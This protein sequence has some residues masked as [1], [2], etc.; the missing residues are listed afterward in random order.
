[1]TLGQALAAEVWLIVP[2][3]DRWLSSRLAGLIDCFFEVFSQPLVFSGE[4]GEPVAKRA[5]RFAL[6]E[7]AELGSVFPV[8]CQP[9]P[10]RFR[11]PLGALPRSR[12]VRLSA[13]GWVGA[14]HDISERS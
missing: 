10:R 1:M 13:F 7:E 3:A 12:I 14:S 8:M 5:L 9:F 4:I 6:G 2:F 11:S